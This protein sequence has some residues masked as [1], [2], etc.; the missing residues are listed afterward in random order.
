M[1]T[2][3]YERSYPHGDLLNGE[4]RAV[5]EAEFEEIRTNPQRRTLIQTLKEKWQWI[6]QRLQRAL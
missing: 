3:R 6:R 4:A 1:R 2:S 5:I